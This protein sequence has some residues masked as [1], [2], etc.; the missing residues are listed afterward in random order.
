MGSLKGVWEGQSSRVTAGGG[1]EECRSQKT[2]SVNTK[3]SAAE[4]MATLRPTPPPK[5][6]FWP[7]NRRSTVDRGYDSLTDCFEEA[8]GIEEG[9]TFFSYYYVCTSLTPTPQD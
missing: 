7:T 1:H 3:A 5:E 4:L 2:T 6:P 9:E 8:L